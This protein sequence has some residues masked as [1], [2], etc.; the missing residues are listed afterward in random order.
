MKNMRSSLGLLLLVL[1]FAACS[2]PQG[3]PPLND[4]DPQIINGTVSKAGSRPYQIKLDILTPDRQ[5]GYLCG[6]TLISPVWVMTAAHCLVE[7]TWVSPAS[8]V[9]VYAGRYR[10]DEGGQRVRVSRVII[11]PRY[12]GVVSKGYEVKDFVIAPK[13]Y[14][15]QGVKDVV[16]FDP[17]TSEVMHVREDEESR[18]GSPVQIE[19]LCGCVC[20]V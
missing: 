13:F 18:K 20:T 17:Y 4:L 19:L 7:G 1:L 8:G 12:D 11:H 3:R 16:V 2:G 6:G 14:L 15:S 9:T 5:A 10:R